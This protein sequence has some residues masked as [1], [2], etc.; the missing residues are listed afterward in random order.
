LESPADFRCEAIG[1]KAKSVPIHPKVLRFQVKALGKVE[2]N[3]ETAAKPRYGRLMPAADAVLRSAQGNRGDTESGVRCMAVLLLEGVNLVDRD[4][5]VPKL[6][7]CPARIE[8]VS[9]Q[10]GSPRFA[11]EQ[12][13]NETDLVVDSAAVS[14]NIRDIS[15]DL[16][17]REECA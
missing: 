4:G 5:H 2:P 9:R 8:E 6:A 17:G 3:Q 14:G 11:I 7:S 1:R 12:F 13:R 15:Q 16:G 10:A